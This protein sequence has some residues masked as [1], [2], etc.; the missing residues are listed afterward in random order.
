[1]SF[2]FSHK[3]TDPVVKLPQGLAMTHRQQRDVPPAL[4][5][6]FLLAMTHGQQRDVPPAL[7]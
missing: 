1:V 6:F 5:F 2:F 4:F 3:T 7:G